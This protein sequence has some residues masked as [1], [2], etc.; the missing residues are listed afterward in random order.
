MRYLLIPAMACSTRIR[1]DEM[2]RLFS[3]SSTVRSLPFG[4]L[5]RLNDIDPRNREYENLNL[6]TNNYHMAG[7]SPSYQRYASCI[8]PSNNNFAIS[9]DEQVILDGVLLL[10]T[11]VM[12]P[13]H[14]VFWTLNRTFGGIMKKSDLGGVSLGGS[15]THRHLEGCISRNGN[16]PRSAKARL[17]IAE[18]TCWQ[19][20]EMPKSSAKRLGSLPRRYIKIKSNLSQSLASND[21]YSE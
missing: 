17:T 9:S 1:I 2:A 12:C 20:V 16:S 21:F 19:Q 5:F 8:L 4:F 14:W 6:D 13:V 7:N 11:T 3:F 10:F 18:S 15:V